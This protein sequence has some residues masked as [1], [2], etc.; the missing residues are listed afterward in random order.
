MIVFGVI[1][2]IIGVVFA[3]PVLTYVGVALAVIGAVFWLLGR[4]GHAVGGRRAWY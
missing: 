1:L 2:I 3:V 4:A